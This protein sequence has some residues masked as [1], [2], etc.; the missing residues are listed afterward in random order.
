MTAGALERGASKTKQHSKP[1]DYTY[2]EKSARDVDKSMLTFCTNVDKVINK[3]GTPSQSKLGHNNDDTMSDSVKFI[4][5]QNAME[6][7]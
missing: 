6:N 7:I 5:D 1:N 4:Y 2:D 3:F